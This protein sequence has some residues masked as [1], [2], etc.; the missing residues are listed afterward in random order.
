MSSKALNPVYLSHN[1]Q[2]GNFWELPDEA[3]E[4]TEL[5]PP[6]GTNV[7]DWL[8]SLDPETLR[9]VAASDTKHRTG[10]PCC[11]R[12]G[13]EGRPRV[14]ARVRRSAWETET[15]KLEDAHKQNSKLLDRVQRIS[16]TLDGMMVNPVL[17]AAEEGTRKSI[18]AG[19]L[20]YSAPMSSN[21]STNKGHWDGMRYTASTGT[22][23]AFAS[24]ANGLVGGGVSLTEQW[25]RTFSSEGA[26]K[27]GGG[28]SV[29]TR[30]STGGE[31]MRSGGGRGQARAQQPGL[32]RGALARS[33]AW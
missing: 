33:T 30:R 22:Q 20:R 19:G 29:A 9:R 25:S 10:C 32:D 17:A 28:Q 11:Q 6:N 21:A 23:N 12:K 16:E 13:F 27:T 24:S 31:A 26:A 5:K 15:Q 4:K 1:L 7:V 14:P 8:T 18:G 2:Y 3:E